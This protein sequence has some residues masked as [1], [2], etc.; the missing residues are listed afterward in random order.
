MI[1]IDPPYGVQFGSNF[2]PFVR[3]RDVSHNND[4]DMTREP[5]VVQA[6]RDTW[7]LGLHSYLTYL[8]D[9]LYLARELLSPTGSIFVQISDE[10]LPYLRIVLDE[11]FDA[12]NFVVT[13]PVKKKGGQ[14]SSL[15]D[16]VNDYLIWFAKDKE[17]CRETY[18][19][20]FEPAPLDAE[21]V[22][23]FRYVELPDG[24]ELTLTQLSKETNGAIDY[25][26]EPQ[27]VLQDFPGARIF[28]SENITGG[29]PGK[30]QAVIFHY[31]G[32]SYDHRASVRW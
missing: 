3:K 27:R 29:K 24:R 23:T 2:Q 22:K 14:K 26:K 5:E 10:N 30:S 19:Q 31:K 11:V 18:S 21:L 16:P 13:I 4:E 28:K 15:L 25:T 17:R 6:Y 32:K 9:R 8:R 12:A 1:Y 20:L 7:E